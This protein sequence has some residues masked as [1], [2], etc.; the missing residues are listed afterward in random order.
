M[1]TIDTHASSA[2]ATAGSGVAGVAEW[3]TTTD[4]K[5]IGRLYLGAAALLLLG[6]QRGLG[7]ARR[8]AHLAHSRVAG[9][10][11]A[12]A[13]VRAAALRAHVP[14]VAAAH[15]RCRHGHRPV[16][17]G[18]PF[19]RLPPPRGQPVLAVAASVPASAIYSIINN[20]GPGGGNRRFV[21]LFILCAA[22]VM[23]GLLATVISLVTTILTTRAPGMNMRRLPFFTWSVLV[24][25]VGLAVALPVLIG[26][27]LYLFA[28][29]RYQSL[30]D[31]SGNRALAQWAGFGFT[32]PPPSCSRFPP[33][34]C[35]PRR[36]PPSPASVCAPA[37]SSSPASALVGVAVFATVLQAPATLAPRLPGCRARGDQLKDLLP[38]ALV[39]GAALLGASIAVAL[40]S[41]RDWPPSR[42]SSPRSCS[43]CSP[44]LNAVRCR[45]SQRTQPHRRRRR[46]PVRSRRGTWL[47]QCSP[48]CSPPWAASPTG[49]PKWWGR[50]LPA[51]ATLPLAL[52]AFARRPSW[53]RCRCWSPASPISR[54]RVPAG[55]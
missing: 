30:S 6:R 44:A 48:A 28:A 42:R 24:T 39:H 15:R 45:R 21:E 26:N 55:S 11:L 9:S 35:S 25:S 5:R 29:Y 43:H 46:S 40:A 34:A 12:H 47:A 54:R 50:S 52:L 53:P 19:A 32:R 20:G 17:G 27:L 38:F 2:P 8:R 23:A 31:L 22:L 36:W 1:T 49:A 3:L 51:K 33:S 14:R 18:R 16:A 7:A 41:P 13:A 10:R 4:H 37:A